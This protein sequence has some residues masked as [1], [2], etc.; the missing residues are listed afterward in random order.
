MNK[1]FG[2]S[3]VA[4]VSLISAAPLSAQPVRWIDA[5]TLN[6]QV[7]PSVGL[8]IGSRQNMRCVFR[9]RVTGGSET[10]TG[11]I[12]RLGLDVGFSAAGQLVWR[13]R[14]STSKLGARELAGSYTGASG[15]I[16][17]GAGVGANVLVG[18]SN[19]TISLQP[20][21]VKGQVGANLALGI[22]NLTLQ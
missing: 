12:G 17:V 19:R 3:I 18:G 22:A 20:L 13:V 8:I 14:T 1:V 15:D 7:G 4:A 10:Y 6:C 11:H 16:S 9:S 5:G 21:S 2:F